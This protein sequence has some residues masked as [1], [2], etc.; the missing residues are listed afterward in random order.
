M[1]SDIDQIWLAL[2]DEC[3]IESYSKSHKSRKIKE[4]DISHFW[5]SKKATKRNIR[6]K[7]KPPFEHN[8]T[9]E[10]C[11]A[12]ERIE[13][14]NYEQTS[15]VCGADSD[16]DS[17][18]EKTVCA[19]LPRFV[20]LLQSE[21]KIERL[22]G[23][24]V[25]KQEINSLHL[26]LEEDIVPPLSNAQPYNTQS[27]ALTHKQY[28]ATV[29][30]LAKGNHVKGWDNWER[31]LVPITK[32]F[33]H[34]DSKERAVTFN[35][36]NRS[37]AR[38]RLQ[39][40]LD[41]LGSSLFQQFEDSTEQ[42]RSLAIECVRVLC[43]SG[44]D[45][46]KQIAYIMPA[47]MSRYPETLY[48][49]EMKVF[50]R[51]T[52]NHAFYKRGGA[53][54]REDQKNVLERD[55]RRGHN[56]REPSEEIR[57]DLCSLLGCLIRS[58]VHLNVLSL[59]DAYFSDIILAIQS[60]LHDPFPKL[61]IAAADLLV[62][63]LRLPTWE[64]GAKFYAVAIGRST[65]PLLRHKSSHVRVACITL[66]E[67]SISV[68]DREKIKGAGS[69]AIEDLVGFRQ[70][71]ILP[72]AAFYKSDCG[73]TVNV[74]AEL[75]IDD[76]ANVRYRCCQMLSFLICCLPDR[77]DFQQ[78]LLPYLLSFYSDEHQHIRLHA[79]Q[80]IENCGQQYEAENPNDIIE[81]RQ[82]GVDGDC[83]CNY[84]D[85]LP[86]PFNQR[87]RIGARLFVRG[88]TKR[89]FNAL[90]SELRNWMPNTKHQSAKLL[91]IL[92]VYCEEHLTMDFH[93]TSSGIVKAL[94]SC[95]SANDRESISL[96]HTLESIL[97]TM[98]RYVDPD[99]YVKLLL[100]RVTGDVDSGTSFSEGGEHSEYS[101]VA[102]TIAL[103]CLIK[104]SSPRR[105]L[106]HFY[107][108]LTSLSSPS[109]LGQCANRRT[110]VECL[111]TVVT[112]FEK[113]YSISGAQTA[114]FEETGRLCDSNIVMQRF[115]EAI[116]EILVTHEGD[117]TTIVLART[118]EKAIPSE[119]HAK[120]MPQVHVEK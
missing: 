51:D 100:P 10:E 98:G 69:S 112:M 118:L 79:M 81:R 31:T 82:Y 52:E 2:K 77:Y 37:E 92:V 66:L 24:L 19:K 67:T 11:K 106:S 113:G 84:S 71:N 99:T 85:Q 56:A 41:S 36:N 65:L 91:L 21:N 55:G 14:K 9:A 89:F 93:N 45:F 78:R 43:L 18:E 63:I 75:A 27:I 95:L 23:L 104:G 38:Q 102:N 1:D 34:H 105:V 96:Q 107:L 111:R 3:S 13:A 87:P 17:D 62:Q 103:R 80:A 40:I 120:V 88:N 54:H 4:R 44:L 83:R 48:D 29:S 61:K 15:C 73:I 12:V 109:V 6:E 35:A 58:C 32:Q 47:I 16:D 46:G 70:E 28:G 114:Y 22:N 64:I 115:K 5:E 117:E 33:P 49:E 97:T 8:E 26:E 57:F 90:V 72:I 20:G 7:R 42:C 68:P 110:R 94:Q 86:P 60:H 101:C 119:F 76:N 74:L 25:L 30:D 108:L 116:A 39:N 59:L 53:T 50:V